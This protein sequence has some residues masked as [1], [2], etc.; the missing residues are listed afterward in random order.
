MSYKDLLQQ[1]G[2]QQETAEHLIYIYAQNPARLKTAHEVEYRD[3]DAAAKIAELERY[4]ADLKDYRQALAA[5]YAQ[6]DTM[7][8]TLR[9]ELERHPSAWAGRPITYDVRIVKT[10]EDG[11]KTTELLETYLGKQRREALARF[12]ELKKQRP[13]IEVVKDIDRRSWE[14]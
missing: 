2:S 7:A 14:R 6:L 9:L 10:Y 5:R 12:E 1:Y 11:T 3:K 13:G 4:I 8:Y